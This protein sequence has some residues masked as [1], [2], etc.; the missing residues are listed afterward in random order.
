[1]ERGSNHMILASNCLTSIAKDCE[2]N[3]DKP[4]SFQKH[5]ISKFEM[6]TI[7]FA[8]V[9]L[10]RLRDSQISIASLVSQTK[11]MSSSSIGGDGMVVSV[12]GVRKVEMSLKRKSRSHVE[13]I[14]RGALMGLP[15]ELQLTIFDFL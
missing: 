14:G 15:I 12:S 8:S 9:Q 4:S 5:S 7:L 6:A 3:L 13:D 1:M 11:R 10:S 2:E